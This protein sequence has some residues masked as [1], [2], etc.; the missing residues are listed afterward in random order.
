MSLIQAA[1]LL[2]SL[3]IGLLG[4]A[5]LAQVASPYVAQLSKYVRLSMLYFNLLLVFGLAINYLDA[6]ENLDPKV[7]HLSLFALLT[8]MTLFK[9]GFV[10]SLLGVSKWLRQ[11]QF[12]RAQKRWAFVAYFV[13]SLVLVICFIQSLFQKS[14][15]VLNQV[16]L[17]IEVFVF[18][19]ILMI[20]IQLLLAEKSDYRKNAANY[21]AGIN[22]LVFVLVSLGSLVPFFTSSSFL[23]VYRAGILLLYNSLL[24]AWSQIYLPVLVKKLSTKNRHKDLELFGRMYGISKR[25]LEV[26]ELIC[27]GKT[28]QEI[29][30]ALFISIQTVKD[31]NYRIFKK[32]GVSNRTQLVSLFSSHG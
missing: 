22:L 20:G 16:L 15:R 9:F 13:I 14:D 17:G 18:V 5:R 1:L 23:T 2:I 6:A 8:L 30:D 12:S 3:S 4:L 25:E 32:V 21:F 26:L 19:A 7:F 29:A 24:V 11:E 10:H 27:Q 28:N 31:H